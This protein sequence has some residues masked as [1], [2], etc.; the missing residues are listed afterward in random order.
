[1]AYL[2][3]SLT[4]GTRRV[5]TYTATASQTTFSA[6]YGVGAVDVYQN[7][8]LLAPTDY[9]AT[10]GTT[11]ALTVGAAVNDEIT[12]ICHNTFSVSD[13]VSASQGG[14]FNAGINISSGN[15][16]IGT[17]SPS[18][19]LHIKDSNGGL[20]QTIEAG[21]S[22][23]AYTKYINSTTGNGTYTDGL[24][25]GLDTDE[26]A[27]I[28]L[29]EANHMKFGTSGTERMRIDSSGT[30]ALGSTN[31]NPYN[32]SGSS[33]A[34]SITAPS[35]NTWA[36]LSLQGNG[37]VG[38]GINLGSSGV[39]QA[40]IFSLNGS[41]LSIATNGTNSGTL[42]TERMLIDS[43]GRVT[44]PY[45]P[46]FHA[47]YAN[48]YSYTFNSGNRTAAYGRSILNRGNHYNTSTSLFT[49]PVSG[50][51]QLSFG[52]A[53]NTTTHNAGFQVIELLING[54][55]TPDQYSTS[56]DVV[57]TNEGGHSCTFVVALNANDTVRPQMYHSMSYATGGGSNTWMQARNYFS[58]YLLG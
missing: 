49:A 10:N 57:N 5:Y 14:T 51:Y 22:S 28:W 18:T 41:S 4:E 47:I 8:V 24:L 37:S 54:T 26:S 21:D 15:V 29:Y 40:G 12:I 27:T 32:W 23:A 58:G 46:A 17:S 48:G 25:V 44:M 2:G 19:P 1:M 38:T 35:S 31:S 11:V 13:T 16:G 55:L 30:F 39:R 34:V 3:Q 6:V 53:A 42:L 9:T 20:V 43:A 36:Q 33:G 50:V 45:Q 56:A 52:C 7:G